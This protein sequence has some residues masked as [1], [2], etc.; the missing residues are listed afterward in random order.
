MQ[1]LIVPALIVVIFVQ[2]DSSVYHL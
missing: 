2:E 1:C